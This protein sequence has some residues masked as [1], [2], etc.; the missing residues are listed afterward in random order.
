MHY[1]N[2]LFTIKDIYRLNKFNMVSVTTPREILLSPLNDSK[3]KF[4][5]SFPKASRFP[6]KKPTFKTVIS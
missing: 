6:I 2:F 3:A 1:H 4:Q 5:W